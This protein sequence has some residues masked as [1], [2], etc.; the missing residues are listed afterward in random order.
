MYHSVEHIENIF[1]KIQPK[2]WVI[3]EKDV[4][5]TVKFNSEH[6]SFEDV[7]ALLPHGIY[8]ISM[9]A[10]VNA[11]K[12][13][14]NY[15]FQ[16]GDAVTG[17]G[18]VATKQDAFGMPNSGQ[19][20][21]GTSMM[22]MMFMMMQESKKQSDA[23]M[24]QMN[25]NQVA[26]MQAQH[27]KDMELFKMQIKMKDKTSNLDKIAG[28]LVNPNAHKLLQTA[29]SGGQV[30]TSAVGRL[31]AEGT[32][33]VSPKP[34]AANEAAQTTEGEYPKN[35][36]NTEGSEFDPDTLSI[37]QRAMY[38]KGLRIQM[39]LNKIQ[40]KYPDKDPLVQMEQGIDTILA[41]DDA[42]M[43]QIMMA[44]APQNPTEL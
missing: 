34:Q 9:R 18:N 11:T 19:N 16:Y 23:L 35:T 42:T 8:N 1:A 4:R 30:Q 20:W 28:I 25:Q 41:V 6:G 29:M 21:G 33:P 5:G 43:F 14:P 44:A 27:A 40:A 38:D 22:G 24:M 32:V 17:I 31:M 2:Y 26:A 10:N 15:T 39:V 37:E 12:D 7:L 36:E 13:A 3:R